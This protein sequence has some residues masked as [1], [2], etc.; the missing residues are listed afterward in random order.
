MLD[1]AFPKQFAT[2]R[3]SLVLAAGHRGDSPDAEGALASLCEA[4]WYPLYAHARR[5]GLST[6]EAEDRTQGFFARLLDKDDLAVVDRSR[7]RFRSFLLTAFSHFLANEWDHERAQIR[8]GR[9]RRLSLDV[10]SGESRFV[11]EPSHITTAER[12]FDREW[13]VTLLD[14]ALARLRDE[15]H[16]AGKGEL[17][18][19][20][21]P[22]LAGERGSPYAEIG[23][24]L[25]I[26]EG[27]VKVAA[28][29]LRAR[30]RE[31]VREEIAQTVASPEE[32]D[33]ELR[34]LFSALGS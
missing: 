2:T 26:R 18:E 14:R 3:W 9:K 27:A 4:Y 10:Q 28:H 11:V 1:P 30:G 19:A 17:F 20:L 13:A 29:R 24:R 22:T 33:D 6:E 34:L 7:G 8:G 23:E 15:Y 32:I 25:G 12:I 5:K 16:D 31:L 21:K